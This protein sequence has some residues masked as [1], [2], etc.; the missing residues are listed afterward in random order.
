MGPVVPHFD[1]IQP[2]ASGRPTPAPLT[3]RSAAPTVPKA[4]GGVPIVITLLQNQTIVLAVGQSFALPWTNFPAEHLNAQLVLDVK[5]ILPGNTLNVQPQATWDT[6]HE[7]AIGPP[8][9]LVAV[10]PPTVVNI[11]AAYG[12][13][14]PLFRLL[15]TGGAGGAT[16]TLSAW[17]TPK[18]G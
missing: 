18:S 17:L 11:D 3:R 10:G 16:V 9:A 4:S 15:L 12:P 7:V 6:D 2:G 1:R 14:G 8:I 13:L 5:G